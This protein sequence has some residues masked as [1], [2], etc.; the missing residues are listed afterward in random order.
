MTKEFLKLENKLVLE[1]EIEPIS[2]LIIKL[3]DGSEEENSNKEKSESVISFVT[4]DSPR[5]NLVEYD[6][7]KKNK[8]SREGEIFISG[9][10]LRGLFREKF[11]KIYDIKKENESNFKEKNKNHK[12]VDN[13][14][15]WIEG[16]EAQKGRIF[17]EDAYLEKEELRKNFYL[18]NIDEA[19]SEVIMKRDITPI[20]QFTGKVA[21]PLNYECTIEKFETEL[22][23]NNISLEEMKNIYFILRDSHLGEIRLGNSKTRGFGQVKFNIKSMVIQNYRD[24]T[25]FVVNLKN[26]FEIDFL[27]SIKLGNEFLRENLRLKEKFKEINVKNPNEFIKALFREVE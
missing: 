18:K 3:G 22:I 27:N 23:I 5:G 14:F 4:S 6:K 20:D 24:K 8:D 9:S 19:L 25:K 7:N 1:L 26:Y 15:G 16:E 21:V 17:I 12:E 13:L 11:N 10:T 2:P